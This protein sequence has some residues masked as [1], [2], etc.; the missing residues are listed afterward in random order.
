[1]D[2]GGWPLG[3]AFLEELPRL[4]PLRAAQ[5]FGG[6]A[7]VFYGQDDET[8]PPAWAQRYAQ[9]LGCEAVSIPEANHTFDRLGAVDALLSATA[10]FLGGQR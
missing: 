6:V 5:Q 8:C 2:A 9:A 1:M 3:R 4:N 10:D 7:R